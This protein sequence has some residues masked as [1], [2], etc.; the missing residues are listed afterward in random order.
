MFDV[1]RSMFDVRCSMFDVSFP[2]CGSQMHPTESEYIRPNPSNFFSGLPSE[3][4]SAKDGKEKCNTTL[5]KPLKF[6]FI[7]L[8]N[9]YFLMPEV[10]P[11][12][13]KARR[14]AP[15]LG[16]SNIRLPRAPRNVLLPP[17]IQAL[18]RP[19]TDALHPRSGLLWRCRR[20][21][22]HLSLFVISVGFCEILPF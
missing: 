22:M 14:R 11:G 12:K 2:S 10:K 18:L 21:P 5:R 1:R 15:V 19:R 9:T 4:L 3:A 13:E 17:P 7:A 20:G 6:N 16:R 8:S